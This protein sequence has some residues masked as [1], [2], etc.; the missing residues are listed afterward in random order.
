MSGQVGAAA[1]V[2]DGRAMGNKRHIGSAREIPGV[3]TRVY[4]FICC[5]YSWYKMAP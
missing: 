4:S 2:R 3:N 1:V 5:F